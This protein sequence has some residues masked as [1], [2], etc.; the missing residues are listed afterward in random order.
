MPKGKQPGSV[1]GNDPVVKF[2]KFLSWGKVGRRNN[3]AG[4][5]REV[6]QWVDAAMPWFRSYYETTY[7]VP[8]TDLRLLNI[9]STLSPRYTSWPE[10]D[11]VRNYKYKAELALFLDRNEIP[12]ADICAAIGYTLPTPPDNQPAET[13]PPASEPLPE[14]SEE[15]KQPD[16]PEG[17]SF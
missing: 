15:V 13:E 14:E 2:T 12:L 11:R 5:H 17:L 10:C 9:I 16:A 4:S 3:A 6:M 1:A 7:S 8:L